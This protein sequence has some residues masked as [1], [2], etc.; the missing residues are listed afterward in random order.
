MSTQSARGAVAPLRSTLGTIAADSRLGKLKSA[1]R[2]PGEA[3][4]FFYDAFF[5]NDAV[6]ILP[7]EYFVDDQDLLIMTTLGS[8]IAAS[9]RIQLFTVSP[10]I[11]FPASV[12][13]LS[14]VSNRCMASRC[15]FSSASHLRISGN[16]AL[17]S[18]R[19]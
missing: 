15:R 5:K 8:C 10:P 3:S 11:S 6:K 13:P 18:S 9:A 19:V 16:S 14:R 17:A 4:F 7:G 2:K 1:T 12:S